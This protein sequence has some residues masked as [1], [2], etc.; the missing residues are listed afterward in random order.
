MPVLLNRSHEYNI[1]LQLGL[2]GE[3]QILP[4]Y[5]RLNQSSDKCDM[6]ISAVGD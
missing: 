1:Y 4:D 3:E 2:V 6:G 5:T